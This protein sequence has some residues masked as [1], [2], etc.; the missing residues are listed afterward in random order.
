MLIKIEGNAK[1]IADL[2]QALQGQRRESKEDKC[3][4]VRKSYS[5]RVVEVKVGVGQEDW[6]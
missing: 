1:D 3:V 5:S 6:L 4:L 2:V